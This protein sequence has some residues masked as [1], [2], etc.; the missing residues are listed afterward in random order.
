MTNRF[1][2]RTLS[3]PY[4]KDSVGVDVGFGGVALDVC[5]KVKIEE[6]RFTVVLVPTPVLVGG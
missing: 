5:D 3:V 1:T 4:T 6:E 2:P